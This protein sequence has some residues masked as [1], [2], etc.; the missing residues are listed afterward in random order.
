MYDALHNRSELE[1]IYTE[2][3]CVKRCVEREYQNM[4]VSVK[5]ALTVSSTTTVNN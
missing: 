5:L 3:I 2:I 1:S 4:S